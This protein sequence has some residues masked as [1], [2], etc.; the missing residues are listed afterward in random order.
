V[1]AIAAMIG[2]TS[3]ELPCVFILEFMFVKW[4][5]RG[6]RGL[7]EIGRDVREILAC[8][9]WMVGKEFDGS[10]NHLPWWCSDSCWTCC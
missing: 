4:S 3:E 2:I 6:D 8:L 9:A 5:D 7:A 1:V 10:R